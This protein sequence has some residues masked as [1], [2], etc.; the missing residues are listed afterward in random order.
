MFF[1]HFI[2]HFVV[3]FSAHVLMFVPIQRHTQGRDSAVPEMRIENR[4]HTKIE[5]KKK[6]TNK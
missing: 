6:Q 1:V 2:I 5:T 3:L 4:I